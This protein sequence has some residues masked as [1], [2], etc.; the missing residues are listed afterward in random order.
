M[1]RA[2]VGA[3]RSRGLRLDDLGIFWR[4]DPVNLCDPASLAGLARFIEQQRIAVAF[5]DPSYLLLPV[6]DSASNMF[7]MG[8]HLAG[9]SRVCAATGATLVLVN[10]FTKSAP[11]GQQWAMP[12]LDWLAYSG[13][14]QWCRG[15]HLLNR[16][17]PYDGEQPGRHELWVQVGGSD[18]QSLGLAVDIDE[19]RDGGEWSIEHTP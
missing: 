3:A 8:E 19:G 16:R 14:S 18:G 6:G 7:K 11:Q 12:Q 15:W 9:L 10:H 2:A 5:L 17:A 4:F 1:K 13:F